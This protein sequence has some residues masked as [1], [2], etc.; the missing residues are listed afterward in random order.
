MFIDY[1]NVYMGARSAFD[2]HRRGHVDGQ[3]HP[4]RLGILL[5]D[6]GRSV[7]PTRTLASVSVF[8][9]EPSPQHSPKGQAACQRQVHRW[10]Q[11]GGV[12]VVTRPLK[13]YA[14]ALQDGRTVY[15]A[16]EKGIDVLIALAMVTGAMRDEFDVGI[17]FSADTDLVPAL[18]QVRGA[19]K[20]CEVA[21]WHSPN[22]YAPR[23]QIAGRN[24]WCHWLDELDYRRVRDNTDYLAG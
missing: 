17:L 19:G 9:G 21:A 24:P 1:Q 13:Y 4:E 23:L 2:L 3:V 20:V 16:R 6:R 11:Q 22:R 8:R 15:E 7:D 14:R 10:S 18:E 12:R 5:C